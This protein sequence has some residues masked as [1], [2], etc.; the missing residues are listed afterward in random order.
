MSSL[1]GM[2]VLGLTDFLLHVRYPRWKPSVK[3]LDNWHQIKTN[4]DDPNLEIAKKTVIEP[5]EIVEKGRTKMR[6]YVWSTLT[7]KLYRLI[8]T[9]DFTNKVIE[10]QEEEICQFQTR[11]VGGS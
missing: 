11:S 8:A 4:S 5:E 3:I 2:G 7:G 9:Y 6:M 1:G 10:I